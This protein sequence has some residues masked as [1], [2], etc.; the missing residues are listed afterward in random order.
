MALALAETSNFGEKN[1][2]EQAWR[3]YL[4]L[5][6]GLWLKPWALCNLLISMQSTA[7]APARHC[8]V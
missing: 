3:R 8:D 4:D 1:S 2:L 5:R 6:K 7:I